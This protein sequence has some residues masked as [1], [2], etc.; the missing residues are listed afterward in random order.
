[1]KKFLLTI[2]VL[3]CLSAAMAKDTVRICRNVRS[4]TF[5]IKSIKGTPSSWTWTLEAGQVYAGTLTDSTCGPVSYP[6]LGDYDVDCTVTYPSSPDTTFSWVIRV[7][8][9]AV[10][11]VPINDTTICGSVNLVLDASPG[12]NPITQ[13]LWTPA[14]QKTPSISVSNPGTYG[15]SV[16]TVDDFS[17][18]CVG[19][20]ACDSM[21]KQVTVTLGANPA[22][23]LGPDRFICNSA[24]VTLD[25][26]PDGT[27]YSWQPTG[28]TTQVI[29]ALAQGLY[30][31]SVTNADGCTSTDQIFL[32]DSCPYFI[33]LPNAFTPDENGRND[34]FHWVG[35]MQMVKY[36]FRIFSRWGEKLFETTDPTLAWDGKYKGKYVP[37]SVCIYL[38]NCTDSHDKRHTLKGAFHVLK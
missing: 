35:N 8:E 15:V 34:K 9:G 20:V 1:M 25:A 13:Y 24:P 33:F 17:Y 23:D 12:S 16:F 18:N 6:N 10:N 38:I 5:T 30:S 3:L 32:A 22:V 28:E 36:E 14:G 21:Y 4:I 26:G 31:V 29:L 37:E 2:A 11:S 27:Q 19:C 7:F